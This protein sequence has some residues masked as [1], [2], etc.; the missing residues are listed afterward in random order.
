MDCIFCKIVQ[1]EIP[2]N[3]IYEDEHVLSFV[4]ISQANTGHCV[5]I[6]KKHVKDIHELDEETAKHLYKVV[7][8]LA[9]AIKNAFNADGINIINN[10]GEVAGQ[11]VFHYHIHI[12]PRFKDDGV[13]LKYPS[14]HG[15]YDLNEIKNKIL[16]QL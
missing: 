8:T 15:K 11:T 4:D 2:S 1:G 16:Q 9:T 12:L 10:N 7:P 3:K 6:P 13:V 14:N 5:V